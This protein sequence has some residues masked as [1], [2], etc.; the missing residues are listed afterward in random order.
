MERGFAQRRGNAEVRRPS[1]VER[2]RIEGFSGRWLTGGGETQECSG[3]GDAAGFCIADSA[4]PA[5]S[6]PLLHFGC[7]YLGR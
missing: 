7:D 3:G 5:A 2:R 6:R 1:T 4:V